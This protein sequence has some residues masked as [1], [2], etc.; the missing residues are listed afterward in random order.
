MAT[1]VI[2]NDDEAVVKA[3]QLEQLFAERNEAISLTAKLKEESRKQKV[4]I[5]QAAR[6]V[7]LVNK[8]FPGLKQGQF[9][10]NPMQLMDL[11]KSNN[12]LANDFKVLIDLMEEYKKT[13]PIPVSIT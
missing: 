11:M 10:I 12:G 2:L 9:N 1:Q 13:N 8:M 5:N 7:D 4:L 3:A 6:V